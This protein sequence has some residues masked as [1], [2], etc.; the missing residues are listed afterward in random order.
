[1]YALIRESD[2]EVTQMGFYAIVD[3]SQ[4]SGEDLPWLNEYLE[5]NPKTKD[6]LVFLVSSVKATKKGYILFTPSFNAFVWRNSKPGTALQTGLSD[7]VQ[8]PSYPQLAV[9]IKLKI[10]NKFVIG[11]LDDIMG[12]Y[13]WNAETTVFT[14]AS[15]KSLP[16]DTPSNEKK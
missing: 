8:A 16:L 7:S 12:E 15:Q 2:N 11:F 14:I 4:E 10:S 1:M 9:M 13:Q 3:E 5:L 6:G